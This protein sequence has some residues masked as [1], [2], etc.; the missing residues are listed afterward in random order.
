LSADPPV[1]DGTDDGTAFRTFEA[2][3]WNDRAPTYDRF[4]GRLTSRVLDQLLDA[5]GVV[6]GSRMLDVATGPG[7][8]SAAAERRGA[9]V[10]GVDVAPAM[11]DI[12]RRAN[13][14]LD[15]RVAEAEALPFHDESFDA[16]VSNFLVPHLSDHVRVVAEFC[17]V[18]A[19]NGR[20]ALTTWDT[21]DRMRLLGVF[22]D[23]FRVAGAEPPG[24]IPIGPPFYR[25]ADRGAL[26]MLLI[27]GG[28]TDVNVETIGFNQHVSSKDELWKGILSGTVRTR[29]F[30]TGQGELMRRKIRSAFDTA[31]L[32]FQVAGGFEVPVSVTIGI[33]RKGVDS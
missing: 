25:F 3:G 7:Y 24:D 33:G 16:V 20:V 10:V 30:I 5:A 21:P 2:A 15:F 9:R 13:P 19:N 27:D 29:A 4:I 22:V 32:E 12:A 6:T 8:A 28:F 18:L 11:V 1:P 23:A 31:M 17:R 26:T 14:G